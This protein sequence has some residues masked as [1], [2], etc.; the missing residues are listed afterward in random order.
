[1][2]RFGNGEPVRRASQEML[3]MV[4]R[5]GTRKQVSQVTVWRGRVRCAV[6]E[7]LPRSETRHGLELRMTG[8]HLG[9]TSH[10]SSGSVIGPHM[11]S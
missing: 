1:M 6:R 4:G 10:E 7:E 8:N 3:L 5:R 2:E 11:P 9:S